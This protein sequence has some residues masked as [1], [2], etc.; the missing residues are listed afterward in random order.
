VSFDEVARE[1]VR[2]LVTTEARRAGLDT[3]RTEDLV[4]AVN[5]VVSNS[6]RH[7]GGGGILQIWHEG[8]SLVC[9]VRDRG[10]MADPLV[11]RRK[12]PTS[13]EGGRGLWLVNQICDLVQVRGGGGNVVRM[14]LRV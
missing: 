6:V 3:R 10:H 5:E 12:P 9:E 2:R 1:P 11:G 7:G 4:V 8:G 14:H 13:V